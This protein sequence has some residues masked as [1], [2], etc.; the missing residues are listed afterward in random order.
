MKKYEHPHSRY[1]INNKF[2]KFWSFRNSFFQFDIKAKL[3]VSQNA[4]GFEECRNRMATIEAYIFS[5]DPNAL[6]FC[7]LSWMKLFCRTPASLRKSGIVYDNGNSVF[8]QLYI[9]FNAIC[10][11]L[12]CFLKCVHRIFKSNSLTHLDEQILSALDI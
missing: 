11:L 6:H 9:Q 8:C 10:T 5:T 4:H 3:Y 2:N 7:H 12:T 1:N